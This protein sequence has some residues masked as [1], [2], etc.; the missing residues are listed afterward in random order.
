MSE[1]EKGTDA[2]NPARILYGVFAVIILPLSMVVFFLSSWFVAWTRGGWQGV[3]L[4]SALMTILG[5]VGAR[6]AAEDVTKEE[7]EAKPKVD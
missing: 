2:P 7:K 4:N 5:F 6:L 1:E 3:L